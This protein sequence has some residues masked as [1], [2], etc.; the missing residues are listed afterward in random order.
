MFLEKKKSNCVIAAAT[1]QKIPSVIVVLYPPFAVWIYLGRTMSVTRV[2][3]LIFWPR[4]IP[5]PAWRW[6]KNKNVVGFKIMPNFPIP[7]DFG[8]L[9]ST[10][11]QTARLLWWLL[12]RIKHLAH[13]H[14]RYDYLLSSF[15]RINDA[16]F[17]NARNEKKV[18][19][20]LKHAQK[21]IKFFRSFRSSSSCRSHS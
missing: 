17:I 20:I 21:K 15:Q 14:E 5:F 4:I 2:N 10:E 6:R 7:F 11:S 16:I 1:E 3:A 8:H 13:T 12:F 18:G 19:L 9:R